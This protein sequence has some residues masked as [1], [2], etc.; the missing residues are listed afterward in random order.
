MDTEYSDY[1]NELKELWVKNMVLEELY[2]KF[3]EQIKEGIPDTKFSQVEFYD[4][5]CKTLATYTSKDPVFSNFASVYQYKIYEL[6]IGT[7]YK[8]MIEKQFEEGLISELFY[9]FAV[10][11]CMELYE[12]IV[13]E[14]DKLIDYFGLKTLERSYLLKDKTGKFIERPQIMWL[15]VAIQ[16]HGINSNEQDKSLELIKE[17]Y[18]Y[19][20]KLYFTHATPTLFNSGG[21][22]PQLASCYLLQCPDDL[23]QIGSSFKSIMLLSKWAGGIGINLSDIRSNNSIIKSNGGRTNG[24]IPLCKVLESLARYVNQSSKRLGSIACYLETWHADI[25]DFIELRKNTGDDNLRTRDLF[26]GLWVSDKFMR[27]IENDEDWYLMNPNISTGLTDSWGIEFETLYNNYVSENK[28]VKKIKARELYKKITECQFE[29]GMPYMMFKDTINA[30]SNQQNL[31]TIKNSNLCSEIV[32]YSSPDEIAVCNLA[33]ISLP[34]FVIGTNKKPEFDF[35]ELGKVVQIITNNLNKIID[36]N[37]Y[38]VPETIK[39]N[40]SHRPIGIGV[41]GLADCYYLMGYSFD[42][43]EA[44]MLNK[45][46]F[47]CIYWHSL[48]KSVEIAKVEGY[49]SSFPGSPFSKGLLQFHLAGFYHTKI[50]DN[51]LGLDWDNLIQEIKKYGTRN[52][53]LTTIMPT[54]STA[55]IL[56]NNESIEP[57][58]SNIYVRKVLAGDYVIVNKHLVK[59]LKEIGIWNSD[60]LSEL[61]YDNG[62]VQNL[63]I[64]VY[65]K[66]KYKTAYELKQSVIVKQAVD[67]G[68]FVDQSQSMNLFMGM[69]DHNKLASAHMYSWKNGLKTG[70]YYIRTQPITEGTKFSIDIEHINSIKAKRNFKNSNID[71]FCESCS[72]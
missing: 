41:Q 15:R 69:P 53:L 47:E 8:T 2:G 25:E 43:E 54:A 46:I 27:A 59:D 20:S 61:M 62:S 6:D 14:R 22:Y 64:P 44:I 60:L 50:A 38:P 28:Y 32:E 56:N 3:I 67:R 26:L 24:I 51:E 63:N 40:L 72:A 34:K 17:T 7:D 23:E 42:S 13:W 36:L 31:G 21:K 33:S 58:A 55:Q 57:Y 48:K 1:F 9:N 70:S 16:I 71:N 49:Y 29:T 45:K 5:I 66:N 68:I 35:V 18:D 65:L 52:C 10:T 19:M 30:R 39:S 11:N 37:F 12:M 4:Y